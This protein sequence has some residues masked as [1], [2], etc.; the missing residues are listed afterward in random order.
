[1]IA[2]LLIN[3]TQLTV[4]SSRSLII[5]FEENIVSDIFE[6]TCSVR[7]FFVI[8]IFEKSNPNLGSISIFGN[9]N[10][11]PNLSAYYVI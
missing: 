3:V 7:K 1:M 6:L 11:N 8:T 10:P 2:R 5:Y 9:S 4:F